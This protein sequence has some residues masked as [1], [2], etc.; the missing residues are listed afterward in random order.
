MIE[1]GM[2]TASFKVLLKWWVRLLRRDYRAQYKLDWARRNPQRV[3]ISKQKAYQN[4][5]ETALEENRRWSEQNKAR[6]RKLKTDWAKSPN[7]LSQRRKWWAKN[8]TIN[9]RLRVEHC[10]RN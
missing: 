1:L 5:R 6:H 7:G 10:L 8:Y 3:K 2:T 9:P 4:R